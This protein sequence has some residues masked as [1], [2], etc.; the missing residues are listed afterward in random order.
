MCDASLFPRL[1]HHRESGAAVEA[2]GAALR[3]QEPARAYDAPLPLFDLP[4]ADR[5][6]LLEMTPGSYIGLA[7]QLADEA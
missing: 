3:V 1:T 4:A 5:Q 6:R 7:E 2:F